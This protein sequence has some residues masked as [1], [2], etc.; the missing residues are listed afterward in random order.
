ME[1]TPTKEA[2]TVAPLR[3]FPT[4]EIIPWLERCQERAYDNPALRES[5]AQY[6]HLIRK[7]TGTDLK[8]AYMTA[9][10]ELLLEN[11]NL[12]L[13][14]DLSEAMVEEGRR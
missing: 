9:S 6:I 4:R 10:E 13:V 14:H 12:V 5:V 1:A 2:P 7:L 11:N 3:L 8:G